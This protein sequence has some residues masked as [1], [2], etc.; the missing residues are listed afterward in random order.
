MRQLTQSVRDHKFSLSFSLFLSL[1]LSRFLSLSLCLELTIQAS[2]TRLTSLLNALRSYASRRSI[3]RVY[4]YTFIYIYMCVDS[5]VYFT[6]R[7]PPSSFSYC[8]HF[9]IRSHCIENK[10]HSVILAIV[11]VSAFPSPPLFFLSST[12]VSRIKKDKK[13]KGRC[14]CHIDFSSS[15]SFLLLLFVSF[16]SIIQDRNSKCKV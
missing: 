5:V 9:Y 14:L 10:R 11:T 1:F 12:F 8:V 3:S 16:R 7:T 2:V 13:K 4:I 6:D 15:F